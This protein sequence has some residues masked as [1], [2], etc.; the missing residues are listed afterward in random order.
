MFPSKL[1]M[2]TFR[3]LVSCGHED[4]GLTLG[5]SRFKSHFRGRSSC[6]HPIVSRFVLKKKK[7][8]ELSCG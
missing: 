8:E 5:R 2:K 6:F 4:I 1:V 7:K 3:E